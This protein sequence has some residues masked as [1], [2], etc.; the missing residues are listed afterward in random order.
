[1]F[2]IIKK[3]FEY[4]AHKFLFLSILGQKKTAL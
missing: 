1:M 2:K 3:V 4:Y